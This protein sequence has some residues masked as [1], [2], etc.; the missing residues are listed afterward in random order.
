MLNHTLFFLAKRFVA[1]QNIEEAVHVVRALN[2]R[3][4]TATLDVLG[5]NVEDGHAAENAVSS[6]LTTLDCIQK[7]QLRSNVSLKL[8]QMGLDISRDFCYSNLARICEKAG[9]CHS[10]VRIDMEGSKYTEKTI[11][12]FL[13]LFR[14]Y[15][16]VGIVI[17]AY[18]YRSEQDLRRLIDIGARVRLCKGAYKEP[19]D[20][21]IQKMP[22]IRE[23]FKKLA[24]MLLLRGNY[25]AIATHDDALIRW[26]KDYTRSHNIG[27]ERFEFQ[28]L[29]GVRSETQQRLAQEGYNMR[30]YV[31]FGTHWLPYFYRR[32]R[33]RRENVYFVLKNLFKG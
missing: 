12:V 27:K 2:E 21:A 10:Y 11:S 24:E 13:D 17:Q 1:G 4:I 3:G 18:L 5:E 9:A 31:P 22:E 7:A 26:A 28:M 32:L 19:A 8:T 14:S 23:N 25:P 20:I 16:S 15:K 29:Y 30:V 33:E 6:Y